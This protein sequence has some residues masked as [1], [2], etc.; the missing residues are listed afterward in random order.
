MADK[1]ANNGGNS[2]KSKKP[3]DKRKNPHRQLL[4]RYIKE[5]FKY[6]DLK[7]ILGKLL[8][9]AKKGDVRASTLFLSYIL[10]KPQEYKEIE[11]KDAINIII[12]D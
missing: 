6:K 3:T 12:G 8:K 9:E 7:E 2:T 1:R 11:I 5:D 4:Q 10:G